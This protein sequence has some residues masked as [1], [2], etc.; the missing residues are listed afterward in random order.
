MYITIKNDESLPLSIFLLIA[1]VAFILWQPAVAQERPS[2]TQFI[3]DTDNDGVSAA[4]D[5]DK[6]GDGLIELCSLE[7]LD[8]IR[9]Q[10]DGTG[11]KAS[12]TATR[13][14][15][16]C[17]QGGCRGYEL[18]LSLDFHD[19]NSYD[20][21]SINTAWTTGQGWAP[22][23]RWSQ[24]FR[25]S[26]SFS[27]VF[28]GNGHTISNLMINRPSSDDYIG[29]FG[30]TDTGS[31][32]TNIGLLNVVIIGDDYVGSLVGWNNGD[33]TNSYA[34][35]AV[36]GR[37]SVGGL[38]GDNNG[39]IT[40]SYAT[41]DVQGRFDVG[42]LVGEN[43]RLVGD[44]DGD[45]TNSYATGAVAGSSSVGGLVGQNYGDITN[46]YATGT[47]DGND[48]A[49]GLVGRNSFSSNVTNSRHL[50]IRE[51]RLP[52]T[53][54]GIYSAWS[55]ADWDFG[56]ASQYPALKYT[57]GPDG[58]NP[59]C[60]IAGKPNC[61]SL[62]VNQFRELLNTLTVSNGL[63][64]T[65]FNPQRFVYQVAV[66][67]MVNTITL[68]AT[69]TTDSVITIR[70]DGIG[71]QATTDISS[72]SVDISLTKSDITRITI[73]VSEPDGRKT[74]IYM[75]TVAPYSKDTSLSNLTVSAGTLMP[76]FT[77][78]TLT[79]KV[80]V[81]NTT[82]TIT[83]TPTTT[84][85]NATI[86]VDG[87]TVFNDSQSGDI[88][89]TEGGVTTITI[90]VTAQ[91]DETKRTYTIAV[92]RAP[93]SDASLSNLVITQSNGT[94]I[95][96]AEDFASTTTTYTVD[97]ENTVAQ[98][99]VIPTATHP[100]ATITVDDNTVF[101][102]S[103][104]GDIMLT[105][106]GLTTI[107][108]VVTAQ[109]DETKRTYTIAVDRAPSRDASLRDLVLTQSNG[110]PIPLAE[111]FAPTTTAYTV[112]V[113]NTVTQVQVMPTAAHTN[114]TITVDG[115]TVFSG[116]TSS[117]IMLTEGGVTTITI[118]V[119]AQ[120]DEMKRTYTIAVDRAP[121]SDAS[122]SNL[123]LTQSNGT[124][125]PL[126]EDFAPTTTTYT[127]DVESI[128]AQ[129]QVIPSAT[130]PNAT[131]TVNNDTVVSGTTSSSIM[132]TAGR[133]TTITI[134]VTAQ[135]DETKKTYTIAVDRAAIRVRVKVFLEGPLR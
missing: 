76:V 30:H 49:G 63:L 27:A 98:V 18:V 52:T 82:K 88:K 45:I 103:Q 47:V 113:A 6:D 122:L 28:E 55:T 85:E 56:N 69:A 65:A 11:Y 90:V 31:K 58:N 77:S 35:G 40:N 17:P 2:C 48:N 29:L 95:P 9:Y 67:E 13:I 74:E 61:G 92:D 120:D 110:I 3:E 71:A 22:I 16:G 114:A 96:L 21:G 79:Y 134:V 121:S 34:T 124:S 62:L 12:G 107:T 73:E 100:N 32:M 116:T 94:P 106:G 105:E 135:D 127:V 24:R 25:A 43:G 60:G 64:I 87:N 109:D 84:N 129:V 78:S 91:D 72:I 8:A 123:V 131:I 51:L 50:S 68:Q 133:V 128:V 36:T 4:M 115:N 132:L 38:V 41:G 75:L 46:S 33:I 104:S 37:S 19:A 111:D 66:G 126:A 97:V 53:A 101:S 86:T 80:S 44:N 117:N 102:D 42:G 118:V 23:G 59:A 81:A 93:S 83:V 10:L 119:T 89:L 112:G 54:T 70:S 14:T 99:R 15:T 5:I 20:S 7:G 39:D 57:R 26:Q 1:L 125:I 108:I 130:H